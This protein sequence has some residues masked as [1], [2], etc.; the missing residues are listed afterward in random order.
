MKMKMREKKNEGKGDRGEGEEGSS[1]DEE[2]ILDERLNFSCF[3]EQEKSLIDDNEDLNM[4]VNLSCVLRRII[5]AL[6]KEELDRRENLFHARWKVHDKV[7]SLIID[8]VSYTNVVS[9]SLVDHI[10]I[11]TNKH[12]SL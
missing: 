12:Q 1:R 6:A 4:N 8:S 11:Q 7:C 3:M 10:K 5:V 2:E 9:S